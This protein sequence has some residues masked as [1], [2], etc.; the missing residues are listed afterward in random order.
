[1]SGVLH[2][3][4]T[5]L[6]NAADLSPRAREVLSE[7]ACVY[8]EDTRTTGRLLSF[9]G[10]EAHGLRSLHSHN[11]GAR[12]DEVLRRLSAGDDL[13]LASDAGTPGI[14]DPGSRL[15]AAVHEA[16]MQV[17][18]VPGPSAV[19]ALLSCA[20]FPGASFESLGFLPKAR[21]ARTKLLASKLRPGAVLLLFVPMRDA[22]AL[23][24]DIAEL[25]GDALC[26]LGRELTKKHEELVRLEA[27]EMAAELS[28]RERLLGEATVALWLPPDA[29]RPEPEDLLDRARCG[30]AALLEKGLSRKDTARLVAELCALPRRRATEIV[31][32]VDHS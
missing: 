16:G 20:G 7:V 1:M 10:I 4:A 24:K 13:G 25:R 11:E 29:D 28:A 8:C 17:S 19:T 5:P 15:V 27:T 31:L 9:L 26:V 23:F 14:S 6:G 22:A 32:S 3:V 12:V 2:V 21:G 18:P 30:A